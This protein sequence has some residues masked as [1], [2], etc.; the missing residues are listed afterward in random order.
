MEF[1]VAV[2]VTRL[3]EY[4]TVHYKY[5][6][7]YLLSTIPYLD[8]SSDDISALDFCID[9]R[10]VLDANQFFLVIIDSHSEF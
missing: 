5:D 2:A 6:R 7:Y 10:V 9:F 4:S 1:T 8:Q 3:V